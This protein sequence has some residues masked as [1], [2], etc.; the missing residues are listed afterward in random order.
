MATQCLYIKSDYFVFSGKL[1]NILPYS[2]LLEFIPHYYYWKRG[3]FYCKR[4]FFLV[5]TNHLALLHM[6]F[7]FGLTLFFVCCC[8]RVGYQ[9]SSFF[10]LLSFALQLKYESQLVSCINCLTQPSL[11]LRF[12]L[13][14]SFVYSLLLDL[15][16]VTYVQKGVSSLS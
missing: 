4:F 8:S 1:K 15:Y 12:P 6:G 14:L 13:N 7:H 2:S 10:T 5:L 3:V 9:S 16:P 11:P